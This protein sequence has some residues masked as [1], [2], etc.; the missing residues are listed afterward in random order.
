M[1]NWQP[2]HDNPFYFV[3][4]AKAAVQG[5]STALVLDSRFGGNDAG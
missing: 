1:R 3:T 5:D 4:P 2:A